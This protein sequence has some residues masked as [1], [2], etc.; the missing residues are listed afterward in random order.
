MQQTYLEKMHVMNISLC[1]PTSF[2]TS[3]FQSKSLNSL[4]SKVENPAPRPR[5]LLS[6]L[7]S[8]IMC[9]EQ[10][11]FTCRKKKYNLFACNSFGQAKHPS[12]VSM[13]GYLAAATRTTAP[14][15]LPSSRVLWNGLTSLCIPDV[16]LLA[17]LTRWWIVKSHPVIMKEYITRSCSK[18]KK[19]KQCSLCH[20]Q[21]Q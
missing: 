19:K 20:M 16:A 4:S 7:P 8:V 2:H 13:R 3:W 14:G 18:K 6:K 17:D 9:H 11:C 5:N 21:K 15:L 1:L 10:E 12:R